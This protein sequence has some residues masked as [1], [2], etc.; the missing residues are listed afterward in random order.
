MPD[1]IGEL[2]RQIVE[3]LQAVSSHFETSPQFRQFALRMSLKDNLE[4]LTCGVRIARQLHAELDQVAC[5]VVSSDV[6]ITSSGQPESVDYL[7]L[8]NGYGFNGEVSV[9]EMAISQAVGI[10]FGRFDIRSAMKEPQ[11]LTAD[12]VFVELPAASP[13]LL[14]RKSSQEF[15]SHESADPFPCSINGIL[16]DDSGHQDD[17]MQKVCSVFEAFSLDS[18][19]SGLEEVRTVLG[20]KEL[21]LDCW[22]RSTFFEI[23]IKQYSVSRRKAP[24]YWQLATPSASYSVWCYYHRL[25]RDTFFRVARD[26]ITPKVDHEERKLSALRQEAGLDYSSKHRK[27]IDAQESFVAEL[28][29]FESEVTRI[30]PLWSPNLNDG[31]IINFAP[32][33]RLVPQHKPWQKEC[34]TVWDK[35]VKGDYDWAHLAM[36]L[37]PE[38][39]VPKCKVDRSLAIAHGLEDDFWVEDDERKWHKRQ[40]SGNR[41]E[42]LVAERASTAVK[43][44]LKDLLEA[45]APAGQTRRKQ[46][47]RT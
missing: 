15:I 6:P 27:A 26:Y 33:W 34:K 1:K 18:T 37:W 8:F 10:S 35:L 21:E 19:H 22:L 25:T 2:A 14:T 23:H 11:K 20:A 9:L 41:I 3:A 36:H 16:V 44:A 12:E 5:E 43:A 7:S 47:A 31:V 13:L 30:A 4:I 32:L 28:R 45:P 29:A 46:K 39:V 40:V 24:I 42:E 17:L 38:R